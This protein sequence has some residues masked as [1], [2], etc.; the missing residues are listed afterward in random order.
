MYSSA[1]TASGESNFSSRSYWTA[2]P[3]GSGLNSSPHIGCSTI[4]ALHK[5]DR[6]RIHRRYF[7]RIHPSSRARLISGD[8]DFSIRRFNDTSRTVHSHPYAAP[9]YAAVF[10]GRAHVH[11]TNLSGAAPI[12]IHGRKLLPLSLFQQPVEQL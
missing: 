2:L 7:K 9:K 3:P 10:D 4:S 12:R 6:T 8:G 5:H 1:P 11:S